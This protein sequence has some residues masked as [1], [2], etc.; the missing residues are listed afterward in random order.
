MSKGPFSGH[1]IWPPFLFFHHSLFETPFSLWFR[2]ISLIFLPLCIWPLICRLLLVL[3]PLFTPYVLVFPRWFLS[4][5]SVLPSC[6]SHLFIRLFTCLLPVCWWLTNLSPEWYISLWDRSICLPGISWCP[7][8]T[9]NSKV[10]KSE[11]I[12]QLFPTL[13]TSPQKRK[14]SIL[15]TMWSRWMFPPSPHLPKLKTWW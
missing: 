13:T 7:I 3:P 5:R 10:Y 6:W 4:L 11:L 1:F 14:K 2:V 8:N 15:T 12:P 9:V